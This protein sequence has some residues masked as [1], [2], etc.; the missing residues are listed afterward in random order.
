MVSVTRGSDVE[1]GRSFTWIDGTCQEVNVISVPTEHMYGRLTVSA[2]GEFRTFFHDT[3]FVTYDE[4]EVRL[5]MI[6][7]GRDVMP[8][9]RWWCW[10]FNT[11]DTSHNLME[12]EII[13]KHVTGSGVALNSAGTIDFEPYSL[14]F[15]NE[16]TGEPFEPE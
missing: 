4:G 15:T 2:T 14:F 11:A 9:Q 6:T 3:S 13:S 8:G 10:V 12:C 5:S 16:A 1:L 7:P